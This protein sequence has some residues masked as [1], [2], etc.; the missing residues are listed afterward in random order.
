VRKSFPSETVL[1]TDKYKKSVRR[2]KELKF[3][4]GLVFVT[5]LSP[6]HNVER[7]GLNLI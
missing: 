1:S 2:A 6:E 5:P 3:L 4:I 7:V